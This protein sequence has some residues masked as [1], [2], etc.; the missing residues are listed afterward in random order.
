MACSVAA[1]SLCLSCTIFFIATYSS[2]LNLDVNSFLLNIAACCL[3]CMLSRFMPSGVCDHIDRE[4]V[5]EISDELSVVIFKMAP[6]YF[7]SS[8]TIY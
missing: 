3:T 7:Q 1:L 2:S 5:V 8:G 4:I 6:C